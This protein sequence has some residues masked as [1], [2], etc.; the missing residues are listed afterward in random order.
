MITGGD[1]TT[2]AM[3]I[4]WCPERRAT[5][6]IEK[7]S[8]KDPKARRANLVTEWLSVLY[9]TVGT[10]LGWSLVYWI[11]PNLEISFV[12]LPMPIVV[13]YF[14]RLIVWARKSTEREKTNT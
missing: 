3:N 7:V 13:V 6:K 1:K 12:L 5:S 2:I 4:A 10:I 9:I 11:Y 14:I 8:H